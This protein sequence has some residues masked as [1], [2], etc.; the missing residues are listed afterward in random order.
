MS[1]VDIVQAQFDAYNSQEID[2][3]CSFYAEDCVIADLNG[4]VTQSGRA[5]VRERYGKTWS[6]YP[7]NRARLVNRM[8]YGDIV[9]DHERGERG[10]DGPSFEAICIYTVKNGMIVRV[11][12]AK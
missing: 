7:Q 10:P 9:V 11:D 8:C 12:F 1:A 3:L 6:Q 5:A 4:A 2:L